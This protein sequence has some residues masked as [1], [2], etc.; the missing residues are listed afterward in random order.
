MPGAG[1]AAESRSL[2]PVLTVTPDL[3]RA[4]PPAGHPTPRLRRLTAAAVLLL[5]AAAAACASDSGG[6]TLAGIDVA[7]DVGTKPELEFE[8]PLDIS[9][10]ETRVIVEG[11][12]E[13]ITE[14]DSVNTQYI[15][16]NARTGEELQSTFETGAQLLSPANPPLPYIGEAMTGQTIGSRL[17][18][19]I[20][21]ADGASQLLQGQEPSEQLGAEDSLLFMVDFT[22]IVPET[23]EGE[24]VADV[25]AG[26]PTVET[27]G[28]N[29][30][31]GVTV[32]GGEAPTELVV[33]PLIVGDGDPVAADSTVT[34]HYWGVLWDGGETFDSSWERGEPTPFSLQQVIPGWTEGL[35]GQTVGSRVLLVV[36]PAQGYGDQEQGSIPPNSTLVFVVDILAAS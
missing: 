14:E 11:D 15:L 2:P 33:Q 18:L 8:S 1:R 7:E 23:A 5:T 22:G 4:R 19:G 17:L 24:E 29:K 20:A 28:D 34:A 3:R 16:I 21:P 32:P 30:V 31:T 12:G 35:S 27:D 36:P 25:P 9:E 6:G 13:E 10:S 26:L